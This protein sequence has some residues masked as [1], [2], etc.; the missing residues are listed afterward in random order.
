MISIIRKNILAF[1]D[2]VEKETD[3]IN[4]SKLYQENIHTLLIQFSKLFLKRMWI[5]F[6]EDFK[7]S[8]FKLFFPKK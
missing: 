3:Y 7:S 5:L 1:L 2:D 4:I 8:K 6:V